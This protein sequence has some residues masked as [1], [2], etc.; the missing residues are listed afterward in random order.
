MTHASLFSAFSSLSSADLK[1]RLKT[2]ST[3]LVFMLWKQRSNLLRAWLLR[4]S[5]VLLF[6][7]FCPPAHDLKSCGKKSSGE[8]RFLMLIVKWLEI[9][10]SNNLYLLYLDPRWYTHHFAGHSCAQNSLHHVTE[11]IQCTV[12]V[13]PRFLYTY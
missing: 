4:L 8:T 9:Q 2:R 12:L 5:A 11:A 6:F 3:V 10:L 1:S 7:P 13:F